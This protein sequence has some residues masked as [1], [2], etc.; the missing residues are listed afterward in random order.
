MGDH[1]ID[2]DSYLLKVQRYLSNTC[3]GI[4]PLFA[5]N[6]FNADSS[7]YERDMYPNISQVEG[8]S[9]SALRNILK[10][11]LYNIVKSID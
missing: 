6:K 9:N 4:R 5:S 3:G 1:D 10:L 2:G 11:V 8:I 7:S